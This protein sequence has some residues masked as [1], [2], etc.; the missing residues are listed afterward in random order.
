MFERIA[1]LD[2]LLFVAVNDGWSRPTLDGFFALVTNLGWGHVLALLGFAGF[3][4]FDRKNFPKNFLIVAAVLLLGGWFVDL[5]KEIVGRP[6]PLRDT[7]F[8]PVEAAAVRTQVLGLFD[9]LTMP[10]QPAAGPFAERGLSLRLIGPRL[11]HHSYPSGHAQAAFGAATALVYVYRRWWTWMFFVVAAAVGLSRIYVGVHFPLDV[12]VGG[13]IGVVNAVVVLGA[14]RPYTGMGLVRP[15]AL[16]LSVHPADQ[17]LIMLVA[18]EASADAYA[19]RLIAAMRRRTPGAR[20]IGVGGPQTIEAGLRPL[21]H[22][23]ELAIVGLTGVFTGL[24]AL[25]RIYR[26][27]LRAMDEERPDALVCLDLPDFNLGLAHQAKGRGIPV[28]Y[29]ISP[30]VWA[31]RRKRILTIIDRI[32]RMIVALP[33]ERA[34]YEQHGGPVSFFGH[35]ILETIQRRFATREEARRAFGFDLNRPLLVLAPGSRRNELKRVAPAIAQAGALLARERP[36]LQFAVPLAPTL[37]ERAVRA[38]FDAAGVRPTYT[39]GDFFDLLAC[40]DA[41]LITSGTATLEAALAGL[42]HA[43]LYRIDALEHAIARLVVKTDKIGLPNIILGRVAFRELIQEECNP[44]TAAIQARA[45]LA[46]GSEREAALAACA[47]TRQRLAGEGRPSDAAAGALAEL[48]ARRPR[49]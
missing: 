6:R 31:W 48:I 3:Y 39:R 43:I 17:P 2:H 37:D 16:A 28:L 26:A 14:L 25:R 15:K 22:A 19:A 49:T 18:G 10:M 45:L 4:L 11:A 35:P 47:E 27:L 32:D 38:V 44:Q 7:F 33:F 9:K 24:G 34:L 21:G 12:L 30:Q 20:F 36:D 8:G 41:G 23:H 42:P 40:A 46:P 1:E 13:A 29:Y 5:I